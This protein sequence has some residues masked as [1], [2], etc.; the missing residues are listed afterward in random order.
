MRH[1]RI[2][3]AVGLLACAANAVNAATSNEEAARAAELYR[4][5]DLARAVEAFDSAAGIAFREGAKGRALDLALAAAETQRTRGELLDA[6]ERFRRAALVSPNDPRAAE[7][8]HTACALAAEAL[9]KGPAADAQLAAYDVLLTEHAAGWPDAPTAADAAWRRVELLAPRGRW[10]ELLARVRPIAQRDPRRPRADALRVQA[11]DAIA[12]A[13]REQGDAAIERVARD[14]S[15]ALLPMIVGKSNTWPRSWSDTQRAAAAA[16]ADAHLAR[17]AAGAEYAAPL[18]RVALQGAPPPEAAWRDRAAA[19]LAVALAATRK[20]DEA[21]ECF[22]TLGVT[23]TQAREKLAAAL[24][25][26]LSAAPPRLWP[27]EA[28][29]L[30]RALRAAASGARPGT[31]VSAAETRDQA[32]ALTSLGRADEALALLRARVE[33]DP[34]DAQAAIDYARLLSDSP[35]AKDVQAALAVWTNIEARSARGDEPWREARLARLRLLRRLDRDEQFRRL[36]AV[37]RLL[38]QPEGDFAE[39]L[40]RVASEDVPR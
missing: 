11:C 39:Q 19:Q 27:D 20:H 5:G 10:D 13:A 22:A 30:A 38:A 12:R 2:A 26:R 3:I 16:L 36:L 21:A 9:R 15:D 24:G 14:V 31:P 34:R 6:S 17:G 18:L 35:E 28:P 29:R 40:D 8:H 33:R 1:A 7:A 37:T 25:K 4:A 23:D 32:A